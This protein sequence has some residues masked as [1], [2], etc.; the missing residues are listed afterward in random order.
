MTIKLN[1][2]K[3]I[4]KSETDGPNK[5]ENGINDKRIKL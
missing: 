1:E 5:K 2:T 3:I 4:F